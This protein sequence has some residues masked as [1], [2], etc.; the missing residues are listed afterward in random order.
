M[1]CSR[2]G[3]LLRM[4]TLKHRRQKNDAHAYDYHGRQRPTQRQPFG[5]HTHYRRAGQ[6]SEIPDGGD[7]RYGGLRGNLAGLACQTETERHDG[8]HAEPGQGKAYGCRGQRGVQERERQPSGYA[9]PAYLRE[10]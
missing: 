1:S 8:S 9:R 6:Q 2:Y 4:Q 5:Q 10:I 3:T 7:E